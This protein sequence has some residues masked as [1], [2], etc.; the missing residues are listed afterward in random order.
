[1]LHSSVQRKNTA[2]APTLLAQ[3]QTHGS[4]RQCPA[5]RTHYLSTGAKGASAD[6]GVPLSTCS[7]RAKTTDSKGSPGT[8]TPHTA[9]APPGLGRE[10]MVRSLPGARGQPKGSA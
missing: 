10:T 9:R 6:R 4:T 3:N 7:M 2:R 8:H 5:A 1:M